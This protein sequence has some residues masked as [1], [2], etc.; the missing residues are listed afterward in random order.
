MERHFGMKSGASTV[1]VEKV[2][3]NLSYDEIA[4]A[5]HSVLDRM[6]ENISLSPNSTV[7]VKVNLCLLKGSETGA[8]VDPR[9]AGALV[10]WLIESYNLKKIYVAEADATHLSADMAFQILGWQD[11]FKGYPKVEF[12]NLS[13]D[14]RIPVQGTFIKDLAMSHAMMKTDFLIS[15]AKLKTHTTQKISCIMKNQFGAIP[16]K[17]KIVYHPILAKAIYDA[18]SVRI[19]NL[20]IIDGLVSMEGNGPTNGIPRRTKLVLASNDPVSMD[21]FCARLMGFRPESVPH[22][23]LAIGRGLGKTQYNVLGAPPDPLNLRFRFLPRW[24]EVL[25]KS[26]GLIRRGTINEET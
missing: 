25:K 10:D 15:L 13:R 4:T 14:E 23:K 17:Y 6:K 11:Y 7:L 9:I 8:T 12:L 20:C 3:N 26:I 21:H 24:K 22:L 1:C 2:K 5:L 18:T 19:P 16:Y